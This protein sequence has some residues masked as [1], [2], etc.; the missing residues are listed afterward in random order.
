M[1][2]AWAEW[3]E[4]LPGWRKSL[5][6]LGTLVLWLSL[7]KLGGLRGDHF[8]LGFGVLILG[9]GGRRA[10]ELFKFLLPLILTAIVY[11]TQRYYA[12][13]IRGR[14]RVSEPYFFDLKFFGIHTPQ[15]IKTPNEWLQLHTHPALDF[16][17]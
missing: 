12:D 1:F 5:P 3:W 9:Y 8:F 16:I 10:N 4:S 6:A 13:A 17:T 11:D 2:N 7:W 15:G 14:I